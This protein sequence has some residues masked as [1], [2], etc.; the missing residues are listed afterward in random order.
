MRHLKKGMLAAILICGTTTVHSS[1]TGKEDNP[2]PA[3]PENEEA[4]ASDYSNKANWLS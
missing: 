2:V 1:C 3:N 4:I